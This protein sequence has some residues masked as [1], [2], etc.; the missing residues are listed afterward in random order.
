MDMTNPRAKKIDEHLYVGG[1]LPLIEGP[2]GDIE[3]QTHSAFQRLR[4]TLQ[5]HGYA[6]EDLVR[7]NTYYVYDGEESEATMFWERMTRVRLRYFPDPGPAATAVRVKG[8]ALDGALIQ[9]EAEAVKAAAAERSRIMPADSWDWSIPVPL[10]QG[11]ALDGIVWVGGQISADRSGKAVALGDI[12]EQTQNV[13]NHIG[14]VLRNAGAGWRDLVHLKVCYQ[15]DGEGKAADALLHR[16]V[17]EVKSICGPDLC[18]VTAFGVNLLYEG[19]LLEM[20]A[21]AVIVKEPTHLVAERPGNLNWPSSCG[22]A[23][24]GRLLQVNG[25]SGQDERLD[26]S[27]ATDMAL[28]RVV[29]SLNAARG[30]HNAE[31][32]HLHVFIAS[33]E[34]DTNATG[35][36]AT[37]RDALRQHSLSSVPATAVRVNGLPGG[38][39]I[40]IDGV[41][42]LG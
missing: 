23:R 10:S 22:A 7:L 3:S 16:I 42:R 2:A 13:M 38:A 5:D 25:Q 14:N 26:L 36:M 15:H 11:W 32:A 35:A 24:R 30:G 37:V 40:Q 21:T 19:L 12:R 29:E 20:D 18:P 6:M 41:A 4:S 9:L 39:R 34:A 31:L 27:A 8:M 28:S 1:V 33:P 17:D